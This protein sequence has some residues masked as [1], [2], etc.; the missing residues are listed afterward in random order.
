LDFSYW[1]LVFGTLMLGSSNSNDMPNFQNLA[2]LNARILAIY[3]KVKFAKFCKFGKLAQAATKDLIPMA[4]V[5]I[6]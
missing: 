6:N 2:Y 4:K 3:A 5:Q 1:S